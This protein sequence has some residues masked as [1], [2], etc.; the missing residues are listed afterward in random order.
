MTTGGKILLAGALVFG[1]I[2]GFN[3]YQLYQA[4]LKLK[5]SLE[6]IG[7]VYL[8][9]TSW[10]SVTLRL[11]LS[12]DNTNSDTDIYFDK[13]D[14][15]LFLNNRFAGKLIN[16]YTQIIRRRSQNII[17]F[18]VNILFS[19][20][21]NELLNIFKNGVDYPITLSI[22]GKAFVN[23]LPIPVPDIV[24]ETVSLNKLTDLL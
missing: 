18:D 11:F 4:F 24:V 6:R 17:A 19:I 20:A 10:Q 16:P 3:Y 15:N 12:V 7:L 2:V 1:G 21:G 14:M 22:N 23:G 9:V 5:I 13:I 8:D